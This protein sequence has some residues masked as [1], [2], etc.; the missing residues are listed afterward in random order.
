MIV[1]AIILALGRVRHEDDH[2]KVNWDIVRPNLRKNEYNHLPKS[3][4]T[5]F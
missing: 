4:L 5:D 2:F 1:H 3:L